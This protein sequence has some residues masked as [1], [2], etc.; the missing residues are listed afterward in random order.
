VHQG[1]EP[2]HHV[3]APEE[4]AFRGTHAE[5][6]PAEEAVMSA[7]APSSPQWTL[8]DFG[9]SAERSSP[10]AESRIE[11]SREAESAE[12]RPQVESVADEP[13]GEETPPKEARKGWW[14]RRFKM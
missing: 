5:S 9:G 14:Q 3:S 12:S 11:E 6:A 8:N 13:I 4:T 10:R 2:Q 1:E 7:N